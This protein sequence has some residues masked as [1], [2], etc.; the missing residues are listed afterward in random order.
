[1]GTGTENDCSDTRVGERK[2]GTQIVQLYLICLLDVYKNEF[3]EVDE[4][5]F[6]SVERPC[7]FIFY[8]L[9]IEKRYLDEAASE[10]F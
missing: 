7:E 9:D 8:F 1:M 6:H 10:T 3:G 5:I 2:F 4:A